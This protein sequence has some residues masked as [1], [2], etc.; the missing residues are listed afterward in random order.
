[1]LSNHGGRMRRNPFSMEGKK[2]H[3]SNL[4]IAKNSPEKNNK[5]VEDTYKWQK[6]RAFVRSLSC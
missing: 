4:R 3:K 5:E 6:M 2:K 1:M